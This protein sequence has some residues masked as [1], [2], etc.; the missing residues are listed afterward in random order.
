V[1]ARSALVQGFLIGAA[2]AACGGGGAPAGRDTAHGTF[3]RD[4]ARA[5][6]A[7]SV[8]AARDEWNRAEVVKRLTEAGLVVVDSGRKVRRAG[9][10]VEGRLL[11]VSGSDLELYL[12]PNAAARQRESAALDTTMHGLP[13]AKQPRYIFSGNLVAVHVTPSDRLAERVENSLTARHT[14]AP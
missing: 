6:A 8:A 14:G 12:Y 13:S 2:L 3:A 4:S 5:A 11:R 1:A 7:E 10:H 9:L